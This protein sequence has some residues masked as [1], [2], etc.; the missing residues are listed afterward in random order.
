MSRVGNKLKNMLF[1]LR[2]MPFKHENNLKEYVTKL[3]VQ[4]IKK[5]KGLL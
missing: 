1:D 2:N 5:E 4:K 3:R